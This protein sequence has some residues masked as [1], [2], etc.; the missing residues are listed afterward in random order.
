MRITKA[1]QE[2][3]F[4]NLLA[5]HP[6]Q[7][8]AIAVTLERQKLFLDLSTEIAVKAGIGDGSQAALRAEYDRLNTLAN[9]SLFFYSNVYR[10]VVTANTNGEDAEI[11]SYCHTSAQVYCAG[12]CRAFYID[13]DTDAAELTVKDVTPRRFE[14]ELG[15]KLFEPIPDTSRPAYYSY[16]LLRNSPKLAADHWFVT[17]IDKNDAERR[18]IRQEFTTLKSTVFATLNKFNTSK[19]LV[20]AWPEIMIFLPKDAAAPGTGLALSREDLNAI[21]GL[22]K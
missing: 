18:A 3:I 10:S 4:E 1:I 14:F 11:T 12:Q 20:E 15:A 17:A 6:L 13:G 8:R 19:K 7:E 22:P 9:D 21:C 2:R 5:S 16:I